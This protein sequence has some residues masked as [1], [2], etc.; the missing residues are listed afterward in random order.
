MAQSRMILSYAVL[1]EEE[2]IKLFN[3][4]PTCPKWENNLELVV[5]DEEICEELANILIH[6]SVDKDIR[7]K[8]KNHNSTVT[9]SLANGYD[10]I[11]SK[12]FCC[13]P[14]HIYKNI[15]TDRSY[16]DGVVKYLLQYYQGAFPNIF[17][18][19]TY[20]REKYLLTIDF[21]L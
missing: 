7:D 20:D 16:D 11:S 21:N 19:A 8:L 6:K 18:S 1:T 9:I 15:F 5:K 12:H 10:Q 4:K 3:T 14:K 17:K 13:L 2:A